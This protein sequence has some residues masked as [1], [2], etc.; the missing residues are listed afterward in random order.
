M[1][2]QLLIPQYSETEDI[3]K[4]MLDS[5]EIQQGVDFNEFEV[6]IGNDGSDTKLSAEFL[7]QYSYSLKYFEFEHTSPAGTRQRLFDKA[8]AD[9]VMFCDADDMFLMYWHL[10]LYLHLL[11]RDLIPLFVILWK[12]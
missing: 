6:L 8:I 2:L 7:N 9:Y 4:N 10:Q 11:I 12:K 3:V 5:I 1:K